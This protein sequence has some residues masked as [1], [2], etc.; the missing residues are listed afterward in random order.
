ML[1]LS[2]KMLFSVLSSD[3]LGR[4]D[5]YAITEQARMELLV[6][7]FN[8]PRK[9]HDSRGNFLD[10]ADWGGVRLNTKG[11]VETID[12]SRGWVG[13]N[14]TQPLQNVRTEEWKDCVYFGG[15]W[16]CALLPAFSNFGTLQNIFPTTKRINLFWIPC[17]VTLFNIFQM[18]LYGTVRTAELP[19]PLVELRL[20]YNHFSGTFAL[21]HLPKRIEIV[22]IQR[23]EFEGSLC[24]EKAP[25]SILEMN[26]FSNHFSGTV[27][28]VM[29]PGALRELNLAENDF[30]G[31]LNLSA[32][33]ERVRSLY[34]KGNRFCSP[35]DL[36]FIPGRVGV[37]D[38]RNNAFRQ[39]ILV[40][41]SRRGPSCEIYIDR[42]K[43]DFII[44]SNGI[45]LN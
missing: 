27:D 23:N 32:L 30:H 38:L 22:D 31:S 26:A 36:R 14:S 10:I 34:F 7:N 42:E 43:F 37:I 39:E 12:F 1:Q 2:F 45:E 9:T 29:M 4:L 24:L 35:L 11:C 16:Q 44:D 25:D 28:L 21:E 18:E 15:E 19:P 8:A 6:A 13:S 40:V 5:Y 20:G 17:Q 33:S 3:N 41:N